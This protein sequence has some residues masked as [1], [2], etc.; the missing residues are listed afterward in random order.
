MTYEQNILPRGF[1]RCEDICWIKTNQD[2]T[3]KASTVRQDANSVLQH[4][5]EHCLM[6]IKG[7]VRRS[8]D[9]HVIHANVDTDII[10]SEEPPLGSTQKPEEMY[11]LIEHFSMGRRRLEL[12]GE[13]HNL[14]PGWVTVGNSLSASNFNAET[15]ASHFRNPDG[16]QFSGNFNRPAPGAP[17]LLGTTDDIENLRPRTPPPGSMGQ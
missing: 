6:G 7:T 4:T 10:V 8:S 13:D 9:G 3:R 17:H 11:H 15:Y 12:F 2:P 14:R 16:S 5:K 1:R